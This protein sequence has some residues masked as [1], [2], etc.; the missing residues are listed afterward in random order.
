[1][2][3]WRK[4]YEAGE[5]RGVFVCTEGEMISPSLTLNCPELTQQFKVLILKAFC[6]TGRYV[7][8]T[9]SCLIHPSIL[10]IIKTNV[11]S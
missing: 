2:C 8:E 3:V 11:P 9:T 5:Q 7:G 6:V 10:G 1:M 4:Q